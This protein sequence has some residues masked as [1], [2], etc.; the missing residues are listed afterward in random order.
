MF[1]GALELL[2]LRSDFS[3]HPIANSGN[4]IIKH[5][6]QKHGTSNYDD[7]KTHTFGSG[8][9]SNRD[10]TEQ[11]QQYMHRAK[12]TSDQNVLKT[13]YQGDNEIV[14]SLLK[15][16]FVRIFSSND[17]PSSALFTLSNSNISNNAVPFSHH[18]LE[19][20]R[21]QKIDICILSNHQLVD[22]NVLKEYQDVIS[23]TSNLEQFNSLTKGNLTQL[24]NPFY[25]DFVL[26]RNCDVPADDPL[27]H[28]LYL[29]IFEME[30]LLFQ[31]NS[32]FDH[33]IEITL[34]FDVLHKIAIASLHYQ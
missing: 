14:L 13:L 29:G 25:V 21:T 22:R 23:V 7:H 20:L 32:D 9:I 10:N 19:L 12:R 11:S 8:S 28:R 6:K 15:T 4:F 26:K 34:L 16:H 31:V 18:L 30:K 33:Y 17:N 5:N 27:A 24:N 1:T 3:F 2:Y